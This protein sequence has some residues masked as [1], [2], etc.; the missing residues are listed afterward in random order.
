MQ[1]LLQTGCD[2][3]REME[4]LNQLP[5]TTTKQRISCELRETNKTRR[6]NKIINRGKGKQEKEK[7]KE[8]KSKK[9]WG[10][11]F[12][13]EASRSS[14]RDAEDKREEEKVVGISDV[15]V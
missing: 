3:F 4:I 15:H 11:K 14:D 7:K 2:E 8:G 6:R 12:C 1:S 9:K 10:N 5:P 13:P